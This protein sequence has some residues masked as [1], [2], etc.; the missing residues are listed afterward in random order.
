MLIDIGI[1]VGININ[2]TPYLIIT[3]QWYGVVFAM[4]ILVEV[5]RD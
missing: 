5:H 2:C 4:C 3:V 1:E